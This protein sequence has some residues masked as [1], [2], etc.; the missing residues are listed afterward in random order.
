MSRAP[1]ASKPIAA[2][3][4]Q[5]PARQKGRRGWIAPL[6]L[7]GVGLLGGGAYLA[8]GSQPALRWALEQAKGA[9]F[10]VS[11]AQIGG[12]LLSGVT[13]TDARVKSAFVNG[14]VQTVTVRYDLWAL[15]TRRELR[16]NASLEGGDLSFEPGKLPAVQPNGAPPP[17][18]VS[19]ESVGLKEVS[20]KVLN[21]VFASPDVRVTVLKQTPIKGQTLRGDL[22]LAL[23]SSGGTGTA[24]VRYDIGKDFAV[25]LSVTADL[26][27]SMARHYYE[28]IRAGRVRGKLNVT[29]KFVSAAATISG[30]VLEP[31][32]GLFVRGVSGR[33]NLSSDE[34][35][36]ALLTGTALGGQIEADLAVD[37]KA[38]RWD[39]IGKLQPSVQSTLEAF[40]AGT[41]G[42][43][44]LAVTVRGS[45]WESVD[46]RGTVT[47][48]SDT[49][50]AGF[51]LRA[52]KSDWRFTN[53]LEATASAI[54]PLI[55]QDVALSAKINTRGERVLVDA[56]ANGKL[57]DQPLTASAKID[58]LNGVTSINATGTALRGRVSIA[59]KIEAERLNFST[60]FAKLQLPVPFGSVLTGSAKASG[61]TN[62]LRVAGLLSEATVRVPSVKNT[63]Y[64]GAFNLAWNGR[65][66]SGDARLAGGDLTWRGAILNQNGSSATGDIALN[67]VQLQPAGVVAAQ[68]GYALNA[69]GSGSLRGTAT[70]QQ[71][72]LQGAKLEDAAGPVALEWTGAKLAGRWDADKLLATLTERDLR[73][74][75]K[76]WGLSFGGQSLALGGDLTLGFKDLT[77]TGGITGRGALGEIAATGRGSNLD[78]S[79]TAR[80]EALRVALSGAVKLEPFAL[81]LN[82]QPSSSVGDLS[83]AINLAF[84]K[85]LQ[86]SGTVTTGKGK[87][88]EFALN[89]ADLK[90]NGELD[91]SAL[92]SVLP[93]N[94]RGLARGVANFSYAGGAATA[95]FTGA[96]QGQPLTAQLEWRGG[97]VTTAGARVTGGE[98]SGARVTGQLF[99]SVNANVTYKTLAAR[100][101]GGY[102]DLRFTATGT[103]PR[104]AA[105]EQLKVSLRGQLVT[106]RG[107]FAAGT[108]TGS[109]NLGDLQISSAT[110]RDGAFSA[111]L[112]GTARGQYEGRNLTFERV[113]GNVSYGSS[114]LKLTSKASRATGSYANEGAKLEVSGSLQNVK[115]DVLQNNRAIRANLTGSGGAVSGQYDAQPFMARGLGGV[116]EFKGNAL[117]VN[118]SARVAEGGYVGARARLE[119]LRGA[120]TQAS[121]GNLKLTVQSSSGTAMYA[122]ERALLSAINASL[123]L[124]G[125]RL[126]TGFDAAFSGSPR[127]ERVTGKLSGT[128]GLDLEQSTTEPQ[129]IW[130]GAVNLSASGEHW[131][132][133]A[134]GPWARVRV[135]AVAPTATLAR[136]AQTTL[137][138]QLETVIRAQGFASLPAQTYQVNLNSALGAG[139][140]RLSLNGRVDG[141]GAAWQASATVKDAQNGAGSLSYDSAGRGSLKASSLEITALTQTPATL[142]GALE[143]RGAKIVGGLSGAVAGVPVTARWNDAGAFIGSVGGPVPLTLR[144]TRWAFPLEVSPIIVSSNPATSGAVS[145]G[146]DSPVS[147][148]GALQLTGGVRFKGDLELRALSLNVPGGAISL[149]A[150]SFPVTFSAVDGLKARL[151]GDGSALT[152]NGRNWSGGLNLRY[153]TWGKDATLTVTAAG[154]LSDPTLNLETRGDLN[155]AG[156]VSLER[157]ELFGSLQ[158]ESLTAAL[159]PKLRAQ[160]V[161][162]RLQFKALFNPSALTGK[163]S[164]N[165]VSSS[166]DGEAARL[167]LEAAYKDGLTVQ[168]QL[169]LG[170]SSTRF[171]ASEQG[172]SASQIDLDLRLLRVFGVTA[173][174]ALR[175]SLELPAYGLARSDGRLELVGAKAFDAALDGSVTLQAGRI[176]S[177]LRGTLPGNLPVT[178]RGALYPTADAAIELDGLSGR[179]T[180]SDL[181]NARA[182][183][184]S[185]ALTGRFQQKTANLSADLQAS[186]LKLG[187]AWDALRVALSGRVSEGGVRLS[188]S[189]SVSDLSGLTGVAGNLS[190]RLEVDGLNAKLRALGGVVAGFKIGDGAASFENGVLRLEG[191]GLRNA[192]FTASAKGLL[193]PKL[194]ASASVESRNLYA[195]G[196]FSALASG[197]LTKPIVTLSGQLE[198]A[199]IGLIA[200]NTRV[201]GKF[202]GQNW[203][204]NLSGKAITVNA[205]G[206]LSAVQAVTLEGID[207]PLR[208]DG[209]SVNLKG[210]GAWS[211]Q[212]GFAGKLNASG[213]LIGSPATLSLEGKGALN[214]RLEWRGG[215]LSATL[216]AQITERVNASLEFERFDIAGLWDKP[217]QLWLAGTG[218]VTGAWSDPQVDLDGA[219]SSADKSLDSRLTLRYGTGE[220]ALKLIGERVNLDASLNGA[221]YSATGNFQSVRLEALLPFPAKSL[222]LSGAVQATGKLNDGLPKVSLSSLDLRGEIAPIGAF[223]ATGSASSNASFLS[224]DL[225]V[226]ALSGT[227]RANGRIGAQGSDLKLTLQGIN[228]SPLGV[229]GAVAGQ[230]TLR[231][232]ASDPT[233]SGN[234]SAKGLTL[235]K[236]GWGADATAQISA[237]LLEPN[238][239][240]TLDLT[241]SAK[242]RLQ[243][244]ARK[245]L[246]A[247]PMLSLRGSGAL[248]DGSF[249]AN[250]EGTLP[251]L[252]GTLEATIPTLPAMLQRVKLE[253]NG[254]GAYRVSN[255]AVSGEFSLKAGK[256]LLGT[257][258]SGK[259]SA[260]LELNMLLAGLTGR[261][262]GDLALGGT[263]SDPRA[264][265][266]GLASKLALSNITA[267]DVQLTG[268]LEAGKLSARGVYA[269]GAVNWDGQRVSLTGLPLK[270]GDYTLNVAAT[271]PTAPLDLSYTSTLSGAGSSGTLAGR[272]AAGTLDARLEAMV[273]G[274]A[275]SG[276]AQG[277][278]QRGWSGAVSVN[279]LPKD[280]LFGKIDSGKTAGSAT[281]SLSGPFANPTLKGTVQTLGRQ[282]EVAAA[283]TP[284]AVSLRGVSLRGVSGFS[285]ALELASDKISGSLGYAENGLELTLQGAGTLEQPSANLSAN[286]GQA[287]AAA[288]LRLEAGQP[289]GTLRVTDGAKV[290]N[291]TVQGGRISGAAQ[292]LDLSSLGQLGFGGTVSVQADVRQDASASYGWRGALSA[293]WDK[294]VTPLTLPIL[295]WN[296]DGTG[297]ANLDLDT[298]ALNLEYAGS[299]GTANA[300][301]RL[302][303]GL[304]V[305]AV[306]ADLRGKS[307]LGS[308]KGAVTLASGQIDGSVAVS[309]LPLELLGI[310]VAVSGSATLEKDSFSTSLTAQTLGGQI[311][312][313][314]SGGLSDLAPFL[315]P[316][317]KTAPGDLGYTLRARLDTVKLED[318]DLLHA[319]A[320]GVTGRAIGVVQVTD[321][322]SNF[323]L[324]VPEL[325]LPDLTSDPK[326]RVRL[327]LRITG[328][329]AGSNLRYNGRLVGLPSSAAAA[330]LQPNFD[331][332]GESLFSGSYDGERA[333]G[334][335][336]MR[337]APL[338]SI[339]GS[340]FGALPGRAV[341]T[342]IARY[343]IPFKN[344]AQSE[345]RVALEKLEIEGGGD[346]LVGFA[347][348][349]FKNGNLTLD[350]LDLRGKG[351]WTGAG[352]YTRDGVDLKLNFENTSFT[353]VLALIPTLREYNPDASGTV[354]LE[355]SG[356]YALPDAKL[357]V[358]GFKGRLSG[359]A[360]SAP[361]LSGSL[362][363]GALNVTGTLS[364][365]DTLGAVLE[366]TA[367]AKVTSLIPTN[368]TNLEGRLKGSL[369]VRPIGL[370][371]NIDA[372]VFG[373]SGGFKI[374]ATGQKGGA[375]SV[376]G[377]LS[378]LLNLKLTGRNLLVPVPDYFVSDS[379]VDADLGF[380]GDGLR[381]YILTGNV[382]LLRL[383]AALN[384]PGR[385]TATA[386]ATPQTAQTKNPFLEQIKLG[387]IRVTAPQGVRLNE[388]FAALEA[389]GTLI[390]T[391]TAAAPEATGQLEALGNS[392]GRGFVRLGA[393]SYTIQT[394]VANFSQVEGIY[395][396]VSVDAK[397]KLRAALRPTAGGTSVTQEIEVNL[398][399]DIRWIPDAA[400]TRKLVVEP[401]L[402]S[403]QINGFENLT[404]TELY[405]L[406]TLGSTLGSANAGLSGIGQ[407]ALDTAFSLFFLSEFSRQF[408]EATGVDLTVSTNLFDYIF[409]PPDSSLKPEDQNRLNFTFNLG[410]DLSRAVRLNLEVGTAGKGAVN[411][412]YQSEDGRFG[413]RFNTPFDLNTVSDPTALYGGLQPE[414]GLS[415]NISSLNAFTLGFQYRGNNNFSFKFGFSFRF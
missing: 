387:S 260:K 326:D 128:L 261:V 358:S 372:R 409:N 65:R 385:S 139:D 124:S 106:A 382:N 110:Y 391:G 105:L 267:P 318:I 125:S 47:G 275:L 223:S 310:P 257:A 298:G 247:T 115:L 305:G 180:G 204:I 67:G 29:P 17:V 199:K 133:S 16:L 129:S 176:S 44:R 288:A 265:L 208:W 361:S 311:T 34:K 332:Y 151:E 192:D 221:A 405:S 39:V 329:A 161:A 43:G 9:G 232:A 136:L 235:P 245:L 246:S 26:D 69:N 49:S 224:A 185:L 356:K 120:V 238:L 331:G 256:T 301:L 170:A 68:L 362:K 393:N 278:P 212:T 284:L 57:L 293:T 233:V 198:A 324:S 45:G 367:T 217:K 20:V 412:N 182:R 407:Q 388:S 104:I 202:D 353:P 81:R 239:T 42:T 244:S 273:A 56:T 178:L 130:D 359:I 313:T 400:G 50:V 162:G 207:A 8:A 364:S 177:D 399:L 190:A 339:I 344:F 58:V 27:A 296:I 321:G 219:V 222:S 302:Q 59:G 346:K 169:A 157:A 322:I 365:D 122:G 25:N 184:A 71:L 352:R 107:R 330:S 174:G 363:D 237:R 1:H 249:D 35:V 250:L 282:L 143:L 51:A 131:R 195:P 63:A 252:S 140:Q 248:P 281:L 117:R 53:R 193:F 306:A 54:T 227:V 307:G 171:T 96:L 109:F 315:Q 164:A 154:A 28:P 101:T 406:V 103:A 303:N 414:F 218:R 295:E 100:V 342:G 370:I 215:K 394:A 126:T 36:S 90:A 379:L 297:K 340:V 137:P 24:D 401:I 206:N 46:L 349:N 226:S 149:P 55:G 41:V 153:R 236:L 7:A 240:A 317:T 334:L 325:S 116:L 337:R 156:S 289:Q 266:N 77:L 211:A 410:F 347:A 381:A 160:V 392:S 121:S 402:S 173:S 225:L 201:A 3:V 52:L 403:N 384:Q 88:L 369:N 398:K 18:T 268:Q 150:Q 316:Y 119:G 230:L 351:R 271:G 323:Q 30:G 175:G 12:N 262:T 155:L 327:G 2:N 186:N 283:L 299:P 251:A 308:I 91:V 287:S 194:E 15:I 22:K 148:T 350:Q 333:S 76:G 242:G 92:D 85:T 82:L 205:Y 413:I 60:Q 83:G 335:V 89:G 5:K 264:I 345:I 214:A 134:S 290:G 187:G 165:L 383:S 74:Q 253:G 78:L 279:G 312:A 94:S 141:I 86:A 144:A 21:R 374:T 203:A 152:F 376:T 37:I 112:S 123:N 229:L 64:P 415:Y 11:T 79:G 354:S 188:G 389:G 10:T 338:H 75:P 269:G 38:E 320:P 291:F 159:E 48:T 319:V 411:L 280:S 258:L 95:S 19:L 135:D 272:Y 196:K 375:L 163:V 209:S 6:L 147:V 210:A 66:L 348:A 377:D 108:L 254:N 80:Y 97:R 300:K 4:T 259:L 179:V 228:L 390:L 32:K 243:L 132:V 189:A 231:G 263:V 73:V 142:S 276:G 355:L 87:R 357:E 274:F 99:P 396:V 234:L 40:A 314:G 33:A 158:L 336:E 213:N 111:R 294:V 309:N 145:S 277:D 328:T 168:G 84:A 13:A 61:K 31:I 380:R 191:L 183:V 167:Q 368:V 373:A 255:E 113:N 62:D 286:Y 138:T 378:P 386:T 114:G 70:A 93:T 360:L 127:G 366:T 14:A 23:S 395:P 146:A 285:G 216:P 304:W 397:G 241:G 98:F 166:V 197:T 200:P 181:G 102:D 72:T 341:A 118:F 292:N 404:T 220:A 408:K 371:Q 270:F 343:D 172:L